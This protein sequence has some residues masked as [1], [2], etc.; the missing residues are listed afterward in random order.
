MYRIYYTHPA[1]TNSASFDDI[2]NLTTALDHC[3]NLRDC[4]M[5]YVVMVSD[6]HNMVGK[7]GAQMAGSEYVPQLKN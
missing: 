5:K 6:Y 3:A 4:G 1:H 7:P 2:D